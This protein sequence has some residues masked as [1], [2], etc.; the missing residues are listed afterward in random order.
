MR[1][2][3]ITVLGQVA[4]ESER[5]ET[6]DQSANRLQLW[7]MK[8]SEGMH[9]RKRQPSPKAEAFER[10]RFYWRTRHPNE[11]WS[12]EYEPTIT[13]FLK[14]S[15]DGGIPRVIEALRVYSDE[16]AQ[17]FIDCYDSL[18][19]TDQRLLSLEEISA[20]AALDP[21]RLGEI[22]CAALFHYGLLKTGLLLSSHLPRVVEKSLSLAKTDKGVHDREMMLKAGGVLPIPKSAQ[23]VIVNNAH[24][25]PE[26]KPGTR[27]PLW[28]D[29]GQRLREFYDL[30]KPKRLPSPPSAPVEPGGHFDRL[31]AETAEIIRND[32]SIWKPK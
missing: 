8:T 9:P 29:A 6:F 16:D 21:M 4:K 30:T 15:V 25:E 20:G 2:V 19:Q 22:V 7:N 14:K 23:C 1:E 31:Q 17:A 24:S 27:N 5:G 12:P 28:K 10:L 32:E 11:E 26:R 18:T 3:Q 13:P